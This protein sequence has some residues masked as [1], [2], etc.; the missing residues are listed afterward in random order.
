L[1]FTFVSIVWT[2]WSHHAGGHL[3]A[4]EATVSRAVQ[5]P[6]STKTQGRGESKAEGASASSASSKDLEAQVAQPPAGSALP[7]DVQQ[8]DDDDDDEP[9]TNTWH[10]NLILPTAV[11]WK[12]LVL[13]RWGS[14]AADG[15]V[16]NPEA[17]A[18]AMWIIMPASWLGSVVYLGRLAARLR[19]RSCRTR[20]VRLSS[21]L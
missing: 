8:D 3:L 15:Q 12:A 10:L 17:G 21:V 5:L 18:V 4:F 11:C 19:S 9:R 2:G 7:T 1:L 13:T 16:A 20:I 6:D 14:I